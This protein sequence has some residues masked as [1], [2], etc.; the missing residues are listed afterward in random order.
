MSDEKPKADIQ[1]ENRIEA[2][3]KENKDLFEAIENVVDSCIE[4]GIL[5]DF[6]KANKSKVIGMC[7]AEIYEEAAMSFLEKRAQEND[8]AE[9]VEPVAEQ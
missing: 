5:A 8:C 6:L 3:M 2:E 1:R 9:G 4:D 7:V